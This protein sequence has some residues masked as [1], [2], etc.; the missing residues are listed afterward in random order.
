MPQ[1][2]AEMKTI[3]L[4][5]WKEIA[6]EGPSEWWLAEPLQPIH[7]KFGGVIAY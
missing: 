4:A 3:M 6:A 5:T 1:K 2:T 7:K